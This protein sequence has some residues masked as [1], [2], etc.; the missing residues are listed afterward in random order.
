MQLIL[1]LPGLFD[2]V[3][4]GA[5]PAPH[6][7]RILAASGAPAHEPDGLAAALAARY[8][9][10]RQ[11]DWPL[12]PLR[13]A[14]SGVDPGNAYWLVADPVTLVAGRDDVR[15]TGAVSDLAAHESAALLETLNAHFTVDGLVF[16][17]PRPDRWFVRAPDRPALATRPLAAVTG[18][19]LRHLLPMGADSGT[20]RRWQNEIQMLLH[21]HPV[22]AARER[23]A[24]P[25]V[26]S[27]WFSF[28]GTAPERGPAAAVIRT[29][30]ADGIAAAL[31][32]YSGAPAQA[33]PERLDP[34]S[35]HA[36]EGAVIVVALDAPLEL[37]DVERSWAAPAWAMLA[38]GKLDA[39]TLMADYDGDAA[40]WTA[41][42]P[43]LWRRMSGGIAPP[44]LAPLVAA[45][46][47]ES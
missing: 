4:P 35:A 38:R 9:I 39:L 42:R 47:I 1:A 7:A 11:Q 26:N 41:R 37:G 3:A 24:R 8:G 44:A 31:A 43:G 33:L 36:P 45:A 40:I 18:R 19:T 16:V 22:N 10:A 6:L 30:A 25:P 5:P 34:R 23:A 32:A 14:A 12:A 20:W 46:R 13:L 29:Y 15:L 27:V 2:L 28:G 21:E 17:A